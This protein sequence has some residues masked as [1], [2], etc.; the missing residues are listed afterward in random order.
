[1]HLCLCAAC[2]QVNKDAKE[3]AAAAAGKPKAA[4]SPGPRITFDLE[5]FREAQLAADE[6]AGEGMGRVLW[7]GGGEGVNVGWASWGG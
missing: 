2:P 4:G 7:F 1:M 5:G 6:E 3:A